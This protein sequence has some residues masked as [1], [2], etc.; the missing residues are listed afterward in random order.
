M[1]NI[2]TPD[3]EL[4]FQRLLNTIEKGNLHKLQNVF[5]K[6]NPEVPYDCMCKAMNR[7][8]KSKQFFEWYEE[9]RNR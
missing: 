7:K 1:T 4:L 8:I 6:Y 3:E 9:V 5:R 2:L